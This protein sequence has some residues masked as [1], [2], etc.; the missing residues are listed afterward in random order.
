MSKNL[1]LV[2]SIYAEWE[3]GD[4]TSAAWADSEI[5]YL[6]AD[7]PTPGSWRG[8]AGLWE[9]WRE[10]L[11]AWNEVSAVADE[12]RALDDERILVLH[13]LSGRGKASGLDLGQMPSKG[14]TLFHIRGGKVTKLVDY[15][16]CDRALAD[17]DLKE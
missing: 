4:Y 3:R 12:F 11:S 7:G 17:L 2:R 14:A 6:I 8:L 9:G 5:E 10:W 15:F 1:D 16:D 13:D